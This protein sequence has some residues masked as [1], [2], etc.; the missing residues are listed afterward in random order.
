MND[1]PRTPEETE[2][3]APADAEPRPALAADADHQDDPPGR[4]PG[5]FVATL[6]PRQI[7]GGFAVLAG[8]IVMLRRR[9]RDRD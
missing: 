7:I 2:R 9:R 1:A 4:E 6:S 8:L 5:E 3:A